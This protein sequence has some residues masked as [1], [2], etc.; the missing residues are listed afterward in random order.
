MVDQREYRRALVLKGMRKLGFEPSD[1]DAICSRGG[2][3]RHIPSGTYEV[4][5]RVIADVIN[6]PYGE[7]ASNLGV[8]IAKDI[9]D[10]AGLRAYFSDPVSVDEL[11]PV[12]RI[13]GFKGMERESFFHAL[14][15]KGMARRAAEE[16]GRPY[17][18]PYR[19]LVY[20]GRKAA[21]IPQF[22]ENTVICYSAVPDI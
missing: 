6:P 11:Q 14:N 2:L 5:E 13:S 18:E 15:Q 12:A 10:M 16:L 22:Y 19:E 7:H 4:N 3:L 20:E 8:L 21:F 9:A 1:F 17:D